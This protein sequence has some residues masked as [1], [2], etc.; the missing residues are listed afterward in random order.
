MLNQVIAAFGKSRSIRVDKSSQLTSREF[1]LWAY[2]KGVIL[3]FSR[4]G[5]P[6]KGNCNILSAKVIRAM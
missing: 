2:A 5:K 3:D 1:D 6:T 4:R